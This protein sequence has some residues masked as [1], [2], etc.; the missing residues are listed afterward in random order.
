MP[1]E[2]KQL[3]DGKLEVTLGT[4]ER[5]V[6]DALEV[7]T[8]LAEA[9]Q[10]T[11][12]WARGKETEAQ[13]L[14]AEINRLNTPPAPPPNA[15]AQEEANL[16]KYLLEQNAK[17]MGFSNAGEFMGTMQRVVGATQDYEAQR[18][19]GEFQQRRP[20]FPN[21]EEAQN[22]LI[23][24][25][26]QNGWDPNNVP[27]LIAAHDSLVRDG[28]YKPLSAE[29]QNATWSAGLAASSRPKAPPLVTQ[30]SGPSNTQSWY[31]Q[32]NAMSADDL[33]KKILADQA[34]QR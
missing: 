22:A 20:D 34:A 13:N 1:N 26:E 14:Q 11:K 7:T 25:I 32:A 31:E 29:E 23:G 10:N 30:S 27:T 16:Q 2:I 33:R 18:V 24:F 9:H 5:F 8:K 15:A 4:G 21:T 19:V 12:M 17:A 6:G 3:E 28:K